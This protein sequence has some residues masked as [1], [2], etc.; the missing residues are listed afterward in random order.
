MRYDLVLNNGKV[1]DCW[2]HHEI[3]EILRM[4]Y[5]DGI[6]VV[7]ENAYPDK[8]AYIP[9]KEISYVRFPKSYSSE[10]Y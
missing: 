3:S 8:V 2:T 5:I 6:A 9:R 10:P 1:V 7:R 4:L